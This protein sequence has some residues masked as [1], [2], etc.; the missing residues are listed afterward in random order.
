MRPMATSLDNKAKERKRS[1]RGFVVRRIFSRPVIMAI[2]VGAVSLAVNLVVHG[3]YQSS[4]YAGFL[5][6]DAANY[7]KWA[8]DILYGNI[9][10]SGVFHQAPLY[11]YFLAICMKFFGESANAVCLLQCVLS[12]AA[13]AI[14]CSCTMKMSKSRVAAAAAGLL[15]AFYGIQVF[16]TTKIMS[17]TV[18][19]FLLVLAVRMIISGRRCLSTFGAGICTGLLILA[20]PQ[21]FPAVLPV[22]A[23]YFIGQKRHDMRRNAGRATVFIA[24]ITFVVMFSTARNLFV[25]REFVLVCGNGGENFYIGNNDKANGT[26]VPIEGVSADI[27]YQDTDVAELARVRSGK[28]LTRSAVSK[29]WFRK[30][31]D[32]IVHYPGK[33]AAL[34]WTKLRN[35]FSGAEL[36]NMYINRFE[37]KYI[38]RSMKIAFVGFYPLFA[39]F[40]AGLPGVAR[41]WRRW[42]TAAVF[43][44]VNMASM[45]IFF[46][47]TRFMMLTM[48]VFI[49]VCGLGLRDILWGISSV[50][51]RRRYVLSPSVVTFMLGVAMLPFIIMRDRAFPSQEWRLWMSLGD[52][53]Y[54]S[55]DA[56]RSLEYYMKSS[57]LKKDEPLPA[58][59]A[60]KAL[61][62]M[63]HHEAAVRLYLQTF[64]TVGPADRKTIMRDGDYD[65]VRQCA[66]QLQARKGSE[67][68]V[69]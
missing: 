38:T 51:L 25:A 44:V 53:H 64:A 57:E 31:V 14:I 5:L 36:T 49:M 17:E 10:G 18:A 23:Y 1:G 60:S 11:P 34:Q 43:L 13:S 3:D 8:L 39:L 65:Q 69:P 48:P 56:A 22:A 40:C 7:W 33:Y 55:G 4:P 19:V 21:F 41:R 20:K 16:Y 50:F 37:C 15:Y 59:G 63:G 62:M 52:I 30:S 67:P 27:A 28:E 29:Y 68:S 2:S 42:Y 47:D 26:Y 35:V 12:A 6:W 46:Y 66:K 54:G 45:L 58:F 9:L 24:S 61:F 32:F